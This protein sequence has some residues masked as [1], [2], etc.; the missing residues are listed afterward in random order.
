MIDVVVVVEVV[1]PL[2]V[3]ANVCSDGQVDDM[4]LDDI[5]KVVRY[6]RNTR[7]VVR[8]EIMYHLHE[9]NPLG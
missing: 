1:V 4:M 5:A 8:S 6:M 9:N 2:I 7:N 3:V